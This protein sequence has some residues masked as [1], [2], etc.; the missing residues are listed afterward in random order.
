[1]RRTGMCKL[2]LN[3]MLFAFL[4]TSQLCSFRDETETQCLKVQAY[5]PGIVH[6]QNANIRNTNSFEPIVIALLQVVLN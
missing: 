4:I 6:P 1:M 5:E 2:L 3:C